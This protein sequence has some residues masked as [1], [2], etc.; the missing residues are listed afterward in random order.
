VPGVGADF[1]VARCG[2][3]QQEHR[4]AAL[5]TVSAERK[6]WERGL[7]SSIDELTRAIYDLRSDMRANRIRASQGQFDQ[8]NSEAPKGRDR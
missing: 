1:G 7:E 2:G 8:D 5:E 6:I 4:I 3:N